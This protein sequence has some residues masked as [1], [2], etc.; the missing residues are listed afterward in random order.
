MEEVL[1]STLKML[2]RFARVMR[3]GERVSEEFE[4]RLR[5]A[6]SRKMEAALVLGAS[7]ASRDVS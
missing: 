1:N 6:S 3:F 4:R 2:T 7:A 5:V